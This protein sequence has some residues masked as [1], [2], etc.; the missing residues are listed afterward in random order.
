MV[1]WHRRLSG[2]EFGHTLGESERQGGLARCSP[3]GHKELDMP[4]TEQQEN[5]ITL[6]FLLI[7][8]KCS[9]QWY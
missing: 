2:H 5:T 6:T 8:F 7:I 4:V 3:R 9:A 1:G